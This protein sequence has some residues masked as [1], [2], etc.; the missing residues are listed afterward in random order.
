MPDFKVGD[1]VEFLSFGEKFTGIVVETGRPNHAGVLFSVV[2]SPEWVAAPSRLL[3][4]RKFA[5]LYEDDKYYIARGRPRIISRSNHE[6]FA[7]N[8]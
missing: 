6:N 4:T 3:D 1:L 8:K 5:H 2:W 7:K